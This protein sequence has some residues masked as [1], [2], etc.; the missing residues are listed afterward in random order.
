[1]LPGFVGRLASPTP[2]EHR[3]SWHPVALHIPS[4]K[5]EDS[6]PGIPRRWPLVHAG[7]A[8]N[9]LQPKRCCPRVTR[10]LTRFRVLPD[11]LPNTTRNMKDYYAQ[12]GVAPDATAEVIKA[13]FRKKAA[14]YHPDRNPDATAAQRF[15]DVQEAYEVLSDPERRHAYDDTRRRSLLDDPL[16][17]ARKIWAN[18]IE[19]A[20]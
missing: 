3:V 11:F 15:R 1:M 12:L 13:T 18:V 19:N 16:S 9:S 2:F 7:I 17:S 10:S 5:H 4:L 20:L 6:K 14:Q 8:A